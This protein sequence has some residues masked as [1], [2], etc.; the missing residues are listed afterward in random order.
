MRTGEMSSVLPS[1]D[2]PFFILMNVTPL[3]LFVL[4]LT[5][6]TPLSKNGHFQRAPFANNSKWNLLKSEQIDLFHAKISQF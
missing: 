3:L 2:N 4:H 6:F 5:I 1:A